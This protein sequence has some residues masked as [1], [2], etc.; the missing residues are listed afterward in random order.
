MA[1]RRYKLTLGDGVYGPG[2]VAEI[3]ILDDGNVAGPQA[4][5]WQAEYLLALCI[6]PTT[7]HG[8]CLKYLVLSPRYK[9]VDLSDIRREGGVVAV[10]RVVS[11][12]WDSASKQFD[13]AQVEYWAVGKLSLL[14]E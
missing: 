8:Q 4:Q 1:S 12:Q 6:A 9:G 2:D 13:A 7:Y 14:E 3:I 11:D 5:N 10:G